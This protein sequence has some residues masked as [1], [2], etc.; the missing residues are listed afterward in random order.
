MKDDEGRNL[1]IGLFDARGGKG[2]DI[3]LLPA[4]AIK[5]LFVD[6]NRE[7]YRSI[8]FLHKDIHQYRF[9]VGWLHLRWSFAFAEFRDDTSVEEIKR[10]VEKE[11]KEQEEKYDKMKEN[12]KYKDAALR[13]E[14]E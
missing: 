1:H 4:V 3:F 12:E 13:G 5:D 9:C 2:C 11:Y 6:E 7:K 10:M 14:Y 8:Q